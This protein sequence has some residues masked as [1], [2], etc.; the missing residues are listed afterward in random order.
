ME[1][2]RDGGRW[3][4]GSSALVKKCG[5]IFLSQAGEGEEERGL[6]AGWGR[7]C[8]LLAQC[9]ASPPGPLAPAPPDPQAVSP[10]GRATMAGAVSCLPLAGRAGKRSLLASA[11][12]ERVEWAWAWARAWHGRGESGGPP[13]AR[14]WASNGYITAA[15]NDNIGRGCGNICFE[16]RRWASSAARLAARPRPGQSG[17]GTRRGTRPPAACPPSGYRFREADQ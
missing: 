8:P 6:V 11:C 5:G 7:Q 15:A 10:R 1:G 12:L 2:W 4:G 17:P 3:K 9:R 13:R 14:R 16:P